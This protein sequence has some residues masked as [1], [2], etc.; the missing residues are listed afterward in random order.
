MRQ[1][2]IVSITVGVLITSLGWAAED[3]ETL[4][5]TKRGGTRFLS[6]S[7]WPMKKRGGVSAAIPLEEYLSGKFADVHEQLRGMD[8]RVTQLETRLKQVEEEKALLQTRL[9]QVEGRAVPLSQETGGP[10]DASTTKSHEAPDREKISQ[11]G[12]P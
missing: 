6:L 12:R 10:I 9:Q 4:T 3:K 2:I 8:Q 5:V 11:A 1:W 7:D